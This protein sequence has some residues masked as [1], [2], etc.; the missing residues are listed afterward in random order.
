MRRLISIFFLSNCLLLNLASV[1]AAASRLPPDLLE[2]GFSFLRAL[3][4]AYEG[5]EEEGPVFIADFEDSNA[6][7]ERRAIYT[8][9]CSICFDEFTDGCEIA[10]FRCGH[11][12]CLAC[13]NGSLS[14]QEKMCPVCRRH[15]IGSYRKIHFWKNCVRPELAVVSEKSE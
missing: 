10:V 12:F 2:V 3:F 1:Q 14:Y 9:A 11:V 13:A 4:F 6:P 5:P 7:L 8:N 15:D